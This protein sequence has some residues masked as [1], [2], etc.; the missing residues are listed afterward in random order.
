MTDDDAQAQL[1]R[2]RSGHERRLSK[3][4]ADLAEAEARVKRLTVKRD[5]AMVDAHGDR[6]TGGL[7]YEE[8]RRLV[9]VSRGRVIQIVQGLSDYS[10][11]QAAR[12]SAS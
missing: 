9:G 7:S 8:M 2:Q 4:A 6:T 5:R 11:Q 12:R 3:V 10:K 1:N